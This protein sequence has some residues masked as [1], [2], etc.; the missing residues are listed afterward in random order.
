[1]PKLLKETD[2]IGNERA[3]DNLGSERGFSLAQAQFVISAAAPEDLPAGGAPEVAFAGRSNAGKSSVINA[4]AGRRRLAFVSKR[5]GRTQL[6]NFFALGG[7]NGYLVDLPGYGFAAVPAATQAAWESL[8]GGYLRSR[9]ALRGVVLIMDVRHPLTQLDR[10]FLRW[11]APTQ[12]PVLALLNKADK[13]S[14]QQARRALT[15]VERGLA[16]EAKFCTVRLFSSLSGMGVDETTK[17]VL[18]WLGVH[19]KPPV[20]G[21]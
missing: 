16:A 12:V 8:V 20:K 17:T 2:F 5:P 15:D 6:V 10:D 11:L 18:S 1:M 9:Q 13:L 4:L 14:R 21:E 7:G 19:K 3:R